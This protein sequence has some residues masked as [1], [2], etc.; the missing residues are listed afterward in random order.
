MIVFGFVQRLE[1]VFGALHSR[2]SSTELL[3]DERFTLDTLVTRF[4]DSLLPKL[5]R[6]GPQ[7]THP[8]SVSHF[9]NVLSE[10]ECFELPSRVCDVSDPKRWGRKTNL[11]KL[12]CSLTQVSRGCIG[13]IKIT[14]VL[15]VRTV[16]R[17]SR[18]TVFNLIIEE[19]RNHPED[20]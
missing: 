11:N 10:Q 16:Y 6:D 4:P 7:S 18:S 19:Y 14:P 15:D 9:I 3:F 12:Q 8:G 13:S 2:G 5:D 1:K 17:S 20:S